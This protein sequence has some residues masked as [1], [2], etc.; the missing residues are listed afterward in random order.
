[1]VSCP[2]RICAGSVNKL[3]IIQLYHSV[4]EV[5]LYKNRQSLNCWLV[6]H[7]QICEFVLADIA[8]NSL[9]FVLYWLV[10]QTQ[11]KFWKW[12]TSQQFKLCGKQT[13]YTM[14]QFY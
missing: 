8:S 9:S 4:A 14:V 13:S 2:F 5:L 7:F 12:Y 11:H 1:M 10:Y 6:Y 3:V